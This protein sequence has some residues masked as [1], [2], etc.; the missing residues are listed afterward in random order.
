MTRRRVSGTGIAL[1]FAAHSCIHTAMTDAQR[2][3]VHQLWDS[4]TD[5]PAS[6]TE[7]ALEHLMAGI[8]EM[9]D[10]G[11]AYWLG[12]IRLCSP[13][14]DDPLKG[15]RP[16]AGRYLHPTPTHGESAR[17]QTDQWNRRQVNEGYVR[18]ARDVGRFR[19]FRLRKEM[20]P[21]YFEEEF[22]QTFHASRGFHDQCIVF[23]P[24]NDD[25]ESMFNFQRV[26]V[27]RDFTAAE[28][29]I[30]AY[31]LRGIKWFHRQVALSY[32]LLLAE[33][34]LTPIQR[35]ISRLLLTERSEKQIAAEIGRTQGMTHKHITEIFRKFGVT[36]RAGLMAV[37]LGKVNVA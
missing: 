18:A 5:F 36:G 22:Y 17:N 11:N 26:G 7:R 20:R 19:S 37:W 4:L 25:Y 28:E 8:A 1:A 10:A 29:A 3:R 21:A 15:L 33:T 12:Y 6:E 35:Q 32:G 13:V 31:A 23:F 16:G 24:V 34:P 30:A 27:A 9:I 2:E 14:P